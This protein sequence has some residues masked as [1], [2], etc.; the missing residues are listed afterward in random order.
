MSSKQSY[1][2]LKRSFT[3]IQ[4]IGK[5]NAKGWQVIPC[6]G[7]NILDVI[8]NV[9][10]TFNCIQKLRAVT[11]LDPGKLLLRTLI[12]EYYIIFFYNFPLTKIA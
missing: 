1:H 8:L 3:N 10:G 12:F 5:A 4:I 11:G 7:W 9:C 2:D 6:Q